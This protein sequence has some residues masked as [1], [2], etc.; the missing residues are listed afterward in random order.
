MTLPN[1]CN[2]IALK[3]HKKFL[4]LTNL[5]LWSL[6]IQIR[7]QPEVSL[8]KITMGKLQ[9]RIVH[10]NISN[11]SIKFWLFLSLPFYSP[12]RSYV[13]NIEP[14]WNNCSICWNL[15][16]SLHFQEQLWVVIGEEEKK[17]F[18]ESL[19]FVWITYLNIMFMDTYNFVLKYLGQFVKKTRPGDLFM[20]DP[21]G[22]TFCFLVPLFFCAFVPLFLCSFFLLFRC[23]FVPLLLC[24]F[25]LF[26]NFGT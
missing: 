3:R 18:L 24:S 5:C 9:C 26:W 21:I 8:K 12:C 7:T 4:K 20:P 2:G 23:S 22:W 19:K 6:I 15:N 1:I 13:N 16:Y 17:F 10:N 25:I 14:H 11:G